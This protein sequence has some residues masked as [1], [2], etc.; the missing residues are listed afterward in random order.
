MSTFD[1][2]SVMCES[3][4]EICPKSTKISQ[5]IT[6]WRKTCPK[7]SKIVELLEIFLSTFLIVLSW[8]VLVNSF[9]GT[10]FT[11]HFAELS[12]LCLILIACFDNLLETSFVPYQKKKP[13]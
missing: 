7:L 3:L 8:I 1:C 6:V 13:Q 11:K 5:K 12:Y 10:R 2:D 9:I 4:S